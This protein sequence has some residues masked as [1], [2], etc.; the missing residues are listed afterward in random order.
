M[1][2]EYYGEILR[3]KKFD[4]SL[5]G[6]NQKQV[7]RYLKKMIVYYEEVYK[8]R[9]QL[10]NRIFEYKKQD[11]QLRKAL[12]RVEETTEEIK[13]KAED[14]AYIIIKKAKKEADEIRYKAIKSANTIKKSTVIEN[15]EITKK[16]LNNKQLYEIETKKIISII[17]SKVRNSINYLNEDISKELEGY[18][19][20]IDESILVDSS[21]KGFNNKISYNNKDTDKW[22][23][24]EEELLV[25]YQITKDIVDSNGDLIVPKKTIVTPE[26][27]QILIK[28]EVYGEIFTSIESEKYKDVK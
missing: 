14:E 3:N 27:I 24:K 26:I 1:E 5:Q 9:N 22:R 21:K 12:V 4:N 20:N 11:E 19:K 15:E 18:I 23:L 25:G 10:E 17:Y 6:Y 7:D 16:A 13:K 28:K 2:P 8:E